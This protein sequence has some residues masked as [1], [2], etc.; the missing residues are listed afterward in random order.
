[1]RGKIP[2]IGFFVFAMAA[3]SRSSRVAYS[4]LG[5]DFLLI[6]KNQSPQKMNQKQN[7]ANR[8]HHESECPKSLPVSGCLLWSP[9]AVSPLW[10]TNPRRA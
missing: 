9:D 4:M 5:G 1:M 3:L 7:N 10:I 6:T 8:Q 2:G